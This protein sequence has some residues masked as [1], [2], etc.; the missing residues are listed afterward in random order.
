MSIVQL[1]RLFRFGSTTLDD[2]DPSLTPEQVLQSYSG[3]FPFL[4]HATLAEPIVEGDTLVYQVVKKEV[5]TKGAVRPARK[6][7]PARKK[8]AA[9]ASKKKTAAKSAPVRATRAGAGV[10]R[11]PKTQTKKPSRSRAPRPS[12]AP[13]GPAP[14][15]HRRSEHSPA[16]ANSAVKALR[17]WQERSNNSVPKLPV[18]W[19]AIHERLLLILGRPATPIA[20][21]MSVAML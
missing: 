9:Q 19:V 13:D 12:V 15:S 11:A 18:S 17:D 10:A 2:V 6:A 20:D 3:S 4:A 5:Q 7:N 14:P 21:A 8:K 1:T 16:T